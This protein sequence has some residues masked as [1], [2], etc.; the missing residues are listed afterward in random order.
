[1][2]PI[3][4]RLEESTIIADG[5]DDA[6]IG[7]AYREGIQLAVYSTVKTIET[8]IRDNS[9]THEDAQEYFDY[10]I[11]TAFVGEGTPIFVEDDDW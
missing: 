1:M 3:R 8:L 2:N 9:W 4:E 5:L 7:T 6:L 11:S 10:N